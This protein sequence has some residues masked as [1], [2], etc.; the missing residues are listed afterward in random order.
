MKITL[1]D[2]V[3]AAPAVQKLS[4]QDAQ[5]LSTVRRLATFSRIASDHMKDFD[6]MNHAVLKK[7]GNEHGIIPPEK[8]AVADKELTEAAKKTEIVIDLEMPK[9]DEFDSPKL[10]A[11]DVNKLRLV[12]IE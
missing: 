7:Y 12:G 8:Q 10:N 2:L 6:A 4:A 9:L 5:N 1:L 11:N 3:I